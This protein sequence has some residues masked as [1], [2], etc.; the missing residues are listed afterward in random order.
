[1]KRLGGRT[2][3]A[4]TLIELVMVMAMLMVAA[5]IMLPF[6]ARAKCRCQKINCLNNLKQIGVAFLTWSLDNGGKFP[7]QVS[8]TNGGSMELI[9]SGAV[10]PHFEVMSNELSTP[11][12]LFCPEESQPGRKGADSFGRTVRPGSPNTVPFASDTNLSYFVGV[13]A[14]NGNSRML[15]CG[16]DNF[17]IARIRLRHRLVTIRTNYAVEW[18]AQTHAGKGNI[19][20]A[21]GSVAQVNSA[22][23]MQ[24]IQRADGP[25]TRLAMP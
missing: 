19:S 18:T 17:T 21:D 22:K 12:I 16:D 14:T 6:M 24:A 2:Q 10:F 3:Q 23:L 20:F 15:L 5:A 11:K 9:A 1:M 7:M 4:L 25:R 13:D 8:V